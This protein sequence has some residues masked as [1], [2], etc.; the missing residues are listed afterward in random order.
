MI[1]QLE[2]GRKM[3][4]PDGSTPDQIDATIAEVVT[5]SPARIGFD[6]GGGITLK[7]IPEKAPSGPNTAGLG[8]TLG[9]V[10]EF[11]PNTKP[12]IQMPEQLPFGM[13]K[14]A[15]DEANRR[16]DA[17]NQYEKSFIGDAERQA[18]KKLEGERPFASS[19]VEGA[20]HVLKQFQAGTALAPEFLPQSIQDILNYQPFGENLPAD[21]RKRQVDEEM[22]KEKERYAITQGE[23]PLST[24][25]GELAPYLVTGAAG[26]RGLVRVGEALQAP[27]KKA[28]IG[29]NKAIGNTT[30]ANRLINKPA[31]LPTELEQS[32]N[33][34]ARGVATGAA[35][36]S[37]Q[38]NTTAGEGATTALMG[39]IAGMI[40]PL[41][42]LNKTRNERD[43]AGKKLIDQMYEQGFQITPGIRTGNKA[44][45]TAEAGIRNSDIYAQEFANQIDRPNQRRITDMAGEAIGLNTKDRDLL[46]QQE[47][48]DHMNSLRAGYTTLEQ[49]TT[50]KYGLKQIR[51]AG[52]V[53][54]ELQPTKNRNTSDLDKHRYSIA[55]SF[56]NQLK[57]ELGSPQRGA[58]GRFMGYQFNGAQYQAVRQ[59]LQ[60]EISQ[61]YNSGDK[62]LGEQLKKIQVVL[63]D[64]LTQGMSQ[65]TA[66]QWKDM[67]ERYAMT[68]MLMEGGM[69]P[70]GKVDATKLTSA[71]MNGTEA[72]RTLTGQGGRINKFQDIARFND[73]LHGSDVEGGSLTGLGRSAAPID[74][75]LFYRAYK[76]AMRPIDMF[77][78]S[79]RLNT[80]RMPFIGSKLSPAHGLSPTASIQLSRAINQTE[81]PADYV[82]TKYQELKDMLAGKQ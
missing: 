19:V 43:A 64:S 52:N 37:A 25:I 79:Y 75:G 46:S 41:R 29:L 70:S 17:K 34:I 69:T 22:A 28:S 49:T 65:S 15:I 14:S 44:L 55:K 16:I 5:K 1:I 10:S 48:A 32:Y 6:N 12:N 73:V 66:K 76:G 61:A 72:S 82:Q 60:D 27:I 11:V 40:G 58:N 26:E 56:I 30:E 47:L 4:V 3:E 8:A 77:G 13:P 20:K 54:K 31:R 51:E 18:L 63:D 50:G 78:L 9:A 35:E 36:G 45:Q 2:D 59:R 81:T 24:M 68:K 71:V 33:A 7:G 53:L 23:N 74:R 62:R 39:G 21:E 80:N 38:Y 67:N 57:A 42:V